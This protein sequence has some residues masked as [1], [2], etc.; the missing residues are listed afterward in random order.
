MNTTPEHFLQV[1]K[2]CHVFFV[3][4]ETGEG[5]S[6][7]EMEEKNLLALSEPLGTVLEDFDDEEFRSDENYNENL[8][9][10]IERFG[11]KREKPNPRGVVLDPI[12]KAQP[13]TIKERIRLR[14][15]ALKQSDPMHINIGNH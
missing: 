3:Q 4:Y 13:L 12:F 10:D 7:L 6:G 15:E 5:N 11:W 8:A 9:D 14:Q 1:E 2:S